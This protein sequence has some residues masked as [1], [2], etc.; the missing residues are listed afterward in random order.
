MHL[1]HQPH[2]R[3]KICRRGETSN[4]NSAGPSDWQSDMISPAAPK[5]KM[6]HGNWGNAPRSYVRLPKGSGRSGRCCFLQL[7]VAIWR[8]PVCLTQVWRVHDARNGYTTRRGRHYTSHKWT[9][10]APHTTF[11]VDVGAI[12]PCVSIHLYTMFIYVLLLF[13]SHNKLRISPYHLG[14]AETAGG[15]DKVLA[16]T[17]C[18]ERIPSCQSM[19][20]SSCEVK[21]SVAMTCATSKVF[22][23]WSRSRSLAAWSTWISLAKSKFRSRME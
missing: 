6:A 8:L 5:M 23:P 2:G 11:D 15:R 9:W 16:L 3:N 21:P 17:S 14:N 19:V 1:P 4:I 10:T 18:V 22:V 12:D 20:P 7:L 13:K